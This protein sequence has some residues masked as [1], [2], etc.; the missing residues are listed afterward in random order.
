MHGVVV[1]H[2]LK[3]RNQLVFPNFSHG[4]RSSFRFTPS[5]SHNPTTPLTQPTTVTPYPMTRTRLR[6]SS[7]RVRTR[8][9]VNGNTAATLCIC[10]GAGGN[11]PKSVAHLLYDA[12]AT[13]P[14]ARRSRRHRRPTNTYVCAQAC[15]VIR[16]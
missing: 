11:P 15:Q 14:R 12:R 13:C 5:P 9:P 4:T 16:I 6:T 7:G 2:C 3:S 10:F 8:Q 1:R